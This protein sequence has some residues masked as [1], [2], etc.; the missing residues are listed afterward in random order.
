MIA[1][2]LEIGVGTLMLLVFIATLVA[3]GDDRRW[4]GWLAAAGTLALTLLALPLSPAPAQL[5]GAFVQDGLALFAKRLFLA[6]TFIGLLGGLSL[7]GRPFLRR[8][9]EYHILVLASL[10]GML[11]LASARDLVLL[12]VAFEL[13]SIPLY[14][15]AGFAKRE[16]GAVEAALK[17]FLVGSVS[18]AVMAYGLSFVYGAVRT[19]SLAGVAKAARPKLEH[20]IEVGKPRLEHAIEVSL[21]RIEQAAGATRDAALSAA[22]AA[23]AR[24]ASAA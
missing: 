21:P 22:E 14:I 9:G 3:R 23:R 24:L 4:V 15:L 13:M 7:P 5:G 12:F 18:S 10:L 11:V 20:A 8:A 1:F 17:F 16:A 19:T 2:A 6:A